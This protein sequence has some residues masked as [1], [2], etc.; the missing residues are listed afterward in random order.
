MKTFSILWSVMLTTLFFTSCQTEDL[1]SPSGRETSEVL[2]ARRGPQ[3]GVITFGGQATGLNATIT[4]TQNGTVV[5]NQT[6]LSQTALLPTTGGSLTAS[7]GEAIIEGALTVDTL[8]ASIS[9]QG[10]QTTSNASAT[11]L[12]VTVN[13]NTITA[14]YVASTATAT[15]GATSG[16]ST[17]QNLVVNGNPVTITGAPNQTV[18]LSAGSFI[19][20]NEQSTNKKVKG[21]NINVSAL[22]IIIPNG[23]DIR[24]ATARA[25]IKC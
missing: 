11:G 1:A 2:E 16:S 8:T 19:I 20:I 23:A 18:Y 24:V 22:H 3:S 21:K 13:G 17:I 10:N 6:I 14:D 5:S 15:C 7:H 25:E 9:G 12:N 4:T